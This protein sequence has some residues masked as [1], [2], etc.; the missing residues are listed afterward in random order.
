MKCEALTGGMI[1]NHQHFFMLVVG[2]VQLV[3]VCFAEC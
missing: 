3:H 1:K 2:G